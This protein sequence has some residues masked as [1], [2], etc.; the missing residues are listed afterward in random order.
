M[1]RSPDHVTETIIQAAVE[2]AVED[3]EEEEVPVPKGLQTRNR[4]MLKSQ[5]TISWDTAGVV[6]PLVLKPSIFAVLTLVSQVPSYLDGDKLLKL[7]ESKSAE[8]HGR[9]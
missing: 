5:P 1:R 8:A 9:R 2:E 7:C 4:K 3:L 6:M